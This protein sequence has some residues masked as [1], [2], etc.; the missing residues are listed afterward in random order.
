M[1]KLF[2]LQVERG[3]YLEESSRNGLEILRK[4]IPREMKDG[5]EAVA[6]IPRREFSLPRFKNC[7]YRAPRPSRTRNS[8]GSSSAQ[9]IFR[10]H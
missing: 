10:A 4:S 2:S 9:Y 3:Q 6:L 1:H 8:K 5:A 7:P